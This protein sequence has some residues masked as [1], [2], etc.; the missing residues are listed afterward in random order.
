MVRPR[1]PPRERMVR[2]LER[3][4]ELTGRRLPDFLR[5]SNLLLLERRDSDRRTKLRLRRLRERGR[6]V[7]SGHLAA[8]LRD[9]L[10]PDAEALA[11]QLAS[12]AISFA[13]GVLLAHEYDPG[14]DLDELALDMQAAMLAIAR[15]RLEAGS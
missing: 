13:D 7:I 14:V 15:R 12:L 2:Q 4:L 9:E 5:L 3:A 1:L 6:D 11:S 8:L 10:G